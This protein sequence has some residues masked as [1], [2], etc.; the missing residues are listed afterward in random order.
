MGNQET[1]ATPSDK[2]VFI[3]YNMVEAQLIVNMFYLLFDKSKGTL[4][5]AVYSL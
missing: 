5:Y 1:K 4:G 3:S 2:N